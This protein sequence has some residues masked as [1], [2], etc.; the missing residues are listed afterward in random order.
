VAFNLRDQKIFYRQEHADQLDFL[1]LE[2][3][4]QSR[5]SGTVDL[6]VLRDP[7][8][9]LHF[10]TRLLTQELG[11]QADS[12]DAIIIV[13]PRV[14]LDRKVPLDSLKAKGSTMCPVLYLNY[15][16]N[17]FESWPDTIGSALKAFKGA[18]AH[19]IVFPRDVGVAIRELLSR[20][21][22]RPNS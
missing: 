9:E 3:A 5:A 17:L 14:S 20:V 22:N 1:A 13:G 19:N 10:V 6:S 4:A 15:T 16:S 21:A 11:A 8:S 7:Q 2:K 12:P 18:T